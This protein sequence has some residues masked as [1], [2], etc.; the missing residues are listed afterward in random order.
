MDDEYA[1]TLSGEIVG[2][3]EK[4]RTQRLDAALELELLEKRDDG[5]LYL[6]AG[7]PP[8]AFYAFMGWENWW[9]P[10]GNWTNAGREI[11]RELKRNG[12]IRAPY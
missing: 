7:H 2:I 11:K 4:E 1:D 8:S 6:P 9:K 3:A 5:Y 12:K 10:W